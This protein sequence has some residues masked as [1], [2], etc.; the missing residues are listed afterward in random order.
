M[1]KAKKRKRLKVATATTLS[2]D[3]VATVV[4]F[5]FLRRGRLPADTTMGDWEDKTMADL[6]IDDPP[7]PSDPTLDARTLAADL[8]VQFNGFGVAVDSAKSI[9]GARTKTLRDVVEFCFSRQRPLGGL[10]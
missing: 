4:F 1:A 10:Q 8:Q 7:L 2:L 9:L 5:F 6:Q 3:D